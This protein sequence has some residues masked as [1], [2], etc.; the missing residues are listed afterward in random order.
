MVSS[1]DNW[2]TPFSKCTI[3]DAVG[4]KGWVYGD[5]VH[6]KRVDLTDRVMV[7]GYEVVPESVGICIGLKDKK[8]NEIY[9]G[10]ILYVEFEDKSGGYYL[11]A[12]S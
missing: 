2:W 10:D 4:G 8:T 6:N 5:L 11:Y 3:F 1:A 9:D 7:G 12:L